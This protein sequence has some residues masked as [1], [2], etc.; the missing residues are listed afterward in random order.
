MQLK[1]HT[2]GIK[3]SGPIKKGEEAGALFSG[4]LELD[5]QIYEMVNNIQVSFG[6]EFAS[7]TVTFIPGDIEV[8]AHTEESWAQI[9]TQASTQAE[10]ARIRRSDGRVIAVYVSPKE[11]S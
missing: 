5:G 8:V 2:K 6:E 3:G 4:L 7:V 10:S 1:I 11:D 9:C